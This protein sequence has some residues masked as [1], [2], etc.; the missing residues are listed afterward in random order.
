M[1]FIFLLSLFVAWELL[2]YS[3]RRYSTINCSIQKKEYIE[4]VKEKSLIYALLIFIITI[5][6]YTYFNHYFSKFRYFTDY[7]WFLN[8]SDIHKEHS[9]YGSISI[10]RLTEQFVM[11]FGVDGIS[12]WFILLTTLLIPICLL[13]SWETIK[14]NVFE[15]LAAFFLL[16]ALLIGVFSALDLLLF[17]ILF[18]SILIPM[19]LIIGIWGARSRKIKASYYFFLYTLIGSL[20]MLVGLISIYL[21]VGT[22]NY[23]AL[24]SVNFSFEKEVFYW[25]TFFLAFAVKV[26]MFPFHIWLPE[27]HVEA[28]TA[29]SVLLA[30]IL[31]K[32]GGYGFLRF[33]I[34]LFPNAMV[35]FAPIVY[36]ICILGIVYASLIALRQL[37]LKRIIAYASV[38]HMNF[39]LLGLFTCTQQGLE[40]SIILMLG[41][42]LVSSALFLLVG[43]VYDRYHTRLIQYY[44]GLTAVMP[45]FS[46]LFLFF[47]LAN[48][49]FPGTVN[50][51]GEIL[52]IIG[53]LKESTFIGVLATLGMVFGTAYSIWLFNRVAFGTLKLQYV[54]VYSDLNWREFCILLPLTFFTLLFGLKPDIILESIHESVLM[55]LTSGKS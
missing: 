45:I 28:P 52:I 46:I 19:V 51:V 17:Y 55:L 8:S 39:V 4:W 29:G 24:L 43:V 40:G 1:W 22:L 41:H 30:G 27:A 37:D 48:L 44:G 33:S 6:Q 36:M 54:K 20:F 25:V 34:P 11:Q 21:E 32:L 38:A 35:F 47:S 5:V 3:R 16:E 13:A 7:G 15:Y 49:S 42:G 23:F 26:P 53:L 2:F 10:L 50:F 18:E 9:I 12:I 14:T 31:L